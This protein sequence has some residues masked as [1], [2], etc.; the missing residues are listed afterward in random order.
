VSAAKIPLP[1][2]T[3]LSR[4]HW[5]GCREGRLRVQRCDDCG[6]HVFVP[7]PLCPRCQGARLSW[8]ESAG[9]G[10]LYSFTVVHRPQRPEFEVPYTVA[11]VALDEGF[12]MLSNLVECEPAR[13]AVG[14]RV[15]VVFRRMSDEITLP[16]FRPSSGF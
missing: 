15:E 4:P 3:P 5:D 1:R 7:Q 8:V 14:M 12:F 16:Y 10:S 6:S 13:I 2:P 9:R 11:I